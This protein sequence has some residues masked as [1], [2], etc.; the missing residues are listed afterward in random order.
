M[1]TAPTPTTATAASRT[2]RQRSTPLPA[3]APLPFRSLEPRRAAARDDAAAG[4]P[5]TSAAGSPAVASLEVASPAV[6][7]LPGSKPRL[8]LLMRFLLVGASRRPGIR[9]RMGEG[10]HGS[11][12]QARVLGRRRDHAT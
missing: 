12:N 8:F 2:P 3:F 9:R 4:P 5:V 7:C 10:L 6:R 11:R 1:A